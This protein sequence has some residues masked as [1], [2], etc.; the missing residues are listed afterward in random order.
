MSWTFWRKAASVPTSPPSGAGAA[1]A[2]GTRTVTRT[3]ASVVPP[4]PFAV[5]WKLV[6]LEGATVWVPLGVTSPIPSMVTAVAFWVRQLRTTDWPRSMARGSAEIVAVGAAAG[7]AGA[8]PR[9]LGSMPLLFLWQPVTAPMRTRVAAK[10]E[11]LRNLICV[12][13][14]EYLLLC[15]SDSKKLNQRIKVDCESYPAGKMRDYFQLQFGMSAP[16]PVSAR[17]WV[18]SASMVQTFMWPGWPSAVLA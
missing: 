12:A 16:G 18:P 2:T 5:R 15:G 17:R 1:G 10:T 6:E 14:I 9:A 13:L 11:A 3:S 7:A 4:S 8:G